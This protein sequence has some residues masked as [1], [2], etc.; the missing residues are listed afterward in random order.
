MA[1]DILSVIQ[2]NAA[3]W[4]KMVI[5]FD[6][7]SSL[8]QQ[9][10]ALIASKQRYQAVAAQARVPWPAIA[11][12]HMRECS[13]N[14]NLSIAQGDPWNAVSVRVPIGR[15]PFNSWE[16]AAMDALTNGDNPM[17]RWAH[18]DTIGGTLTRLEMYNGLGYAL[19]T[20]PSPY[21]W[22]RTDQ[23]VAGKFVSDHVFDPT[24]D[25]VQQGCAGLLVCM[26]KQDPTILTD[27]PS[28]GAPPAQPSLTGPDGV[29]RDTLWLQRTLNQLKVNPQLKPD[30]GW[31][32]LTI[33]ALK[34]Y[35]TTAGLS[36]SGRYNLPTLNSLVNTVASAA[37]PGQSTATVA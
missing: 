21:V 1:L 8:E 7:L 34:N 13:Q 10:A 5:D 15:G 19:R 25:D 11:V 22:S 12:I 14:W 30:G 33:A 17:N 29:L 24:V 23:Y 18:W 6:A 31:G 3:R 32:P 27:F 28:W 26:M 37:Q 4:P 2:T 35:Q 9:A 20:S 36:A 16:E